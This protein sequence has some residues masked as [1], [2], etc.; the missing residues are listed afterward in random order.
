M[1]GRMSDEQSRRRWLGSYFSTADPG[2]VVTRCLGLVGM[3][4]ECLGNRVKADLSRGQTTR[5]ITKP[6]MGVFQ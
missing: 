6:M 1:G 2:V 5:E 3:E 4:Q